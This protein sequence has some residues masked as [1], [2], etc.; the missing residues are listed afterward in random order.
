MTSTGLYLD[1]KGQ[2]LT[3][4]KLL[5]TIKR[6]KNYDRFNRKTNTSGEILQKEFL[7]P[8]GIT[9]SKLAKELNKTFR[10]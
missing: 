9:Q 4:L 6:G 2:T 1:L 5:I 8:L 7:E 3:R 10:L